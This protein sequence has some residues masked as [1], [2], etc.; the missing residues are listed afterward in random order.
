MVLSP[1]T[2]RHH[3]A[4]DVDDVLAAADRA[5]PKL[6]RQLVDALEGLKVP[7]LE[8]MLAAGHIDAAQRAVAA[9]TFTS[10]QL[11]AFTEAAL[12]ATLAV[13]ASESASFRIAFNEPN[14]RAIRWAEQNIAVQIV[15]VPPAAATEINTAIVESIKQGIHPRVT[16]RHIDHLMGLQPRH[17]KAVNRVYFKALEDG[18]TVEH[19]RKIA[20]RKAAKLIRYRAE[21]IART[22][23]IRASNMGQQLV[24][25]T[26]MDMGLLPPDTK[27]VWVATGDDRTCKICAVLDGTTIGVR[28]SFAITHQATSFVRVGDK[29]RP[30]AVEPVKYPT[31]EKTPPAHIMCRCKE[32]LAYIPAR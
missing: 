9:T 17:V 5:E 13:A 1:A 19:A 11:L 18:V 16:A 28:D 12:T 32:S 20:D 30:A 3:V 22:E 29:F 14:A 8:D 23:T 4:K 7:G 26:A 27:K 2:T 6:R 25:E 31:T 15:G 21:A 10:A 24:W